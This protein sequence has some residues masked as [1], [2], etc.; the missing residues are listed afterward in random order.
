MPLIECPD[1]ANDVSDQAI[2]C[3]HCG[4]PL[5]TWPMFGYEYRSRWTLFGRR[6]EQ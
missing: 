4:K 6:S 2:T 1:C 3:P 5:R